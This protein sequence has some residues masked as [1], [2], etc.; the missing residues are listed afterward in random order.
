MACCHHPGISSRPS[1]WEGDS[2]NIM[3]CCKAVQDGLLF[4]LSEY[5]PV[6]KGSW[7]T[8]LGHPFGLSLSVQMPHHNSTFKGTTVWT[9]YLCWTIH[10]LPPFRIHIHKY[11]YTQKTQP[12]HLP[13]WPP[14]HT[15][16]K[17]VF[18]MSVN[19]RKQSQPLAPQETVADCWMS[20]SA[21]KPE[22]GAQ[23]RSVSLECVWMQTK[24]LGNPQLQKLSGVGGGRG[25]RR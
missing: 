18:F 8:K 12:F 15:H 2:V 23:K 22:W 25:G 21:P 13:T 17:D 24:L 4:P 16:G 3:L 14:P 5:I 19:E 10:Q 1:H 11:L 7:H 6:T 9:S 20:P